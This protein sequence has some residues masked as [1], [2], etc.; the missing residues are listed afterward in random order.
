M[1]ECTPEELRKMPKEF[2]GQVRALYSVL[3]I[4][5]KMNE[6]TMLET[7]DR[8][9]IAAKNLAKGKKDE[10][11]FE[12]LVKVAVYSP[13]IEHREGMLAVL[14]GLPPTRVCRHLGKAFQKNYLESERIREKIKRGNLDYEEMRALGS[15][16]SEKS[17]A[18]IDA[19]YYLGKISHTAAI[20]PLLNALALLP[21]STINRAIVVDGLAAISGSKNLKL[22]RV[23]EDIAKNDF[24]RYN[25]ELATNW[26]N[27]MNKGK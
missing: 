16:G 5:N 3:K 6:R 9:L 18:A 17:H 20:G 11:V 14:R 23:M 27:K 22:V 13:T 10:K 25:K 21:P 2:R 8:S 26:L 12:H 4:D 19:L 7:I 24:S 1:V 15:E